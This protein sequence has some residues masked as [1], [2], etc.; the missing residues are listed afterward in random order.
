MLLF[1]ASQELEIL[2]GL[3]NNRKKH[4]WT[5]RLAPHLPKIVNSQKL[6]LSETKCAS[7]KKNMEMRH[8]DEF[9]PIY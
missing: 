8:L 7:Y 2:R 1:A 5:I 9:C 6:K 3:A 4:I